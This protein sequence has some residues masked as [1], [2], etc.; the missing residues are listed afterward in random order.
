MAAPTWIFTA[1]FIY[2]IP[3]LLHHELVY[4]FEGKRKAAIQLPIY[5]DRK[6][7]IEKETKSQIEQGNVYSRELINVG[8]LRRWGQWTPSPA[9]PVSH[10]RDLSPSVH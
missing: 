6:V 2:V 8:M 4:W 3:L 1:S 7:K 5:T 9:M 10:H